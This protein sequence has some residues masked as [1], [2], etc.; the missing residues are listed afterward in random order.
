ML[1]YKNP[2]GDRETKTSLFRENYQLHILRLSE[3]HS[4]DYGEKKTQDGQTFF[5]SGNE[6]G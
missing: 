2:K 6:E 5:N 4:K 3:V 1:E